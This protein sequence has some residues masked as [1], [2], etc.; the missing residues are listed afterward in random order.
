MFLSVVFLLYF[1]FKVMSINIFEKALGFL[2]MYLPRIGFIRKSYVV[3]ENDTTILIFYYSTYWLN[4]RMYVLDATTKNHKYTYYYN[5]ENFKQ[6]TKEL[7]RII[8]KI[9]VKNER[10]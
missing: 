4:M 6:C 9:I 1:C 2:S 10:I 5:F 7:R 8:R 3:F